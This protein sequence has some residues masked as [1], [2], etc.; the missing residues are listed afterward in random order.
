MIYKLGHFGIMTDNYEATCDWY[1]NTLN[2][3]AIDILHSPQDE[4][5]VVASFYRIDLGDEFVDHH[6]LLITRE[7]RGTRIHH[8]SFEVEDFDTQLLGH[9]WLQQQGHKALWGVGRHVHGSQLFDYWRDNSKHILE[10]YAD[11]DMV[12]CH[13]PVTHA[14]AG[15]FAIW[16]PGVPDFAAEDSD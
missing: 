16:G 2:L 1:T 15:D 12:N 14:K 10:H 13:T 5:L 4:K 3:T 9:Y 11:G 8:S 7:G 6:S